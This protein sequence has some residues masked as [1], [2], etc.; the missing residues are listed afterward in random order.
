[1]ALLDEEIVEYWLNNNG[2][3]C[4]RGIKT[5]LGEIDFL[6]VKPLEEGYECLHVEVTVSFRPIGY[7]GG[8]PSAKRRTPQEV[9]AGV[10]SWVEKKFTDP[11][12]ALKRQELFPN[13]TW[14]FVLVCANVKHEE[15]LALFE[16]RGLEVVRYR[17]ILEDLAT[18]RTQ[19]NSTAGHIIEMLR[20]MRSE[21]R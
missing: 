4:M 18:S 14:G 12:K 15:E 11:K 21:S 1:M 16:E 8:G 20:Y 10:D 7:I 3:F 13:A 19:V 17:D 9:V 2:Y 6:A 5:G